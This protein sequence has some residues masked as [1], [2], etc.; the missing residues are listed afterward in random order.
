MV[1]S[2]VEDTPKNCVG[3]ALLGFDDNID[4]RKEIKILNIKKS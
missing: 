2:E 4:L 1:S 3:T